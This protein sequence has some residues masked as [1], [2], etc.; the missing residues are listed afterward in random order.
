MKNI[1]LHTILLVL[2]FFTFTVAQILKIN[3]PDVPVSKSA[4]EAQ[5]GGLYKPSSNLPG[6]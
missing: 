2:L 6:Q 3:C 4:I 5:T 1:L